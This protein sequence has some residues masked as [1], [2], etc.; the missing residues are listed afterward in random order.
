MGQAVADD[1]ELVAEFLDQAERTEFIERA[2]HFPAVDADG[3]RLPTFLGS[4]L[5]FG[6]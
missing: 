5:R 2:R 3:E 4:G 6:V 1:V